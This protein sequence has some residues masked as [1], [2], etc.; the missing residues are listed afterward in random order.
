MITDTQNSAKL[1]RH[2]LASIDLSDIEHL[3]DIKL[4]DT[5]AMARAGDTET[6]YKSHFENVL[7]LF[8]QQQLEF[9][10]KEAVSND[11]LQFGRGTFNGLMLI[12]EWCEKQKNLSLSRF[13]KKETLDL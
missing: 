3:K 2:L 12:K 5:D 1:L 10:S 11:Q 9:I 13:D 6:F 4:N 8:I 7:K